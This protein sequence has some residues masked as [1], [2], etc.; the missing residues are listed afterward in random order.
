MVCKVRI[1]TQINRKE[2]FNVKWRE[3]NTIE[4]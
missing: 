2:K 3:T 4:G 1:A